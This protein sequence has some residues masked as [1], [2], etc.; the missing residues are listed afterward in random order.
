MRS[1]P[2]AALLTWWARRSGLDVVVE[3]NGPIDDYWTAHPASRVIAPVLRWLERQ[4]L[5]TS[6][7]ISAVSSSLLDY[8]RRN[9]APTQPAR[10]IPNA[11][12]PELF[13]A[14]SVAH[15]D[16]K[17]YAIF[18]GALA[19]WQGI[20]VLLRATQERDWPSHIGLVIAGDGSERKRVVDA[21]RASDNVTY[22]GRLSR[23]EVAKLVRESLA[24]ISPNVRQGTTGSPV[25][26]YEAILSATPVVASDVPDQGPF[27]RS[28]GVGLTY[29][30]TDPSRL[31]AVVSRLVTRPDVWHSAANA[32]LKARAD[33]TW[34]ARARSTIE[35]LGEG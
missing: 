19:P 23:Q 35:L 13:R 28:A 24:V 15:G 33:H 14:G 32:A 22:L 31:A 20:D 30:C 5:G 6:T 27:V 10:V 11:A 4:L 18:A 25:K 21:T 26:L 16:R 2:A 1:H 12:D 7:H 34:V 29:D 8:A 9:G 3:M 17:A